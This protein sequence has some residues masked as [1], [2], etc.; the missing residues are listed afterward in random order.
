MKKAIG[1]FVGA[2]GM[3]ILLSGSIVLG[4]AIS[5]QDSKQQKLERIAE[6]KE[7]IKVQEK[8]MQ[9]AKTDKEYREAESEL[10]R[11]EERRVGKEW[12]SRWSPDH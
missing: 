8:N 2:L 11:S 6:D 4:N 7:K 3:T 5:S 1:V 9:E 10:K 12:R